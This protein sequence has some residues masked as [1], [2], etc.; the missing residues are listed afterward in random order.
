MPRVADA[1]VELEAD[2]DAVFEEPAESPSRGGNRKPRGGAPTWAGQNQGE[3]ARQRTAAKYAERRKE[4][5]FVPDW[6]ACPALLP[7]KPPGR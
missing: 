3:A 1:F 2:A 7:K 6:V 4:R 5:E